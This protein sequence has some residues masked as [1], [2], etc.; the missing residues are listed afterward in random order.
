MP[1]VGLPELLLLAVFYVLPALLCGKVAADKG[2]KPG[3]LW[4]LLGLVFSWLA[5][6][7]LAVLPSRLPQS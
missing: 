2:F 1:N 3:W 7:I 4:V 5:L 6:L